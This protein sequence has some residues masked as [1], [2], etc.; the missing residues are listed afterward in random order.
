MPAS[1]EPDVPDR[2]HAGPLT[3]VGPQVRPGP[4]HGTAMAH[5]GEILQ[6]VFERDEGGLTH[7]V[8]SLPFPSLH[9]CATF[10]PGRA[11][12]V[13]VSPAWKTKAAGA[14][15]ETLRRLGVREGGRLSVHSSI[16]VERGMGSS[17]ADVVS[18]IRAVARAHGT[19]LTEEDVAALAV[20]A[21]GA[22]DGV[23]FG[24]RAVLYA[25]RDGYVLE[26][27]GGPLP[28]LEV[29]GFDVGGPDV[30]TIALPAREYHASEIEQLR[31]LRSMLRRAVTEADCALLGRTATAS[32]R[33]NQRFLPQAALPL[34]ERI[35]RD[36]DGIGVQVAHS[37]RV[38]AVLFDPASAGL[39]A[40][41][42]H[43]RRQLRAAGVRR[44]W[45]FRTEPATTGEPVLP[46]GAE[47]CEE[48]L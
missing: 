27:L 36:S 18:A 25:N 11:A 14:A 37:G 3:V 41:V 33:L 39:A 45:S 4:A 5:H 29:L 15:R 46:R 32:A 2:G 9:A 21:E 30:D 10:V 7:A 8:V 31:D 24:H 23:M 38:L 19:T 6:G 40:R 20:R 1:V 13:T 12:G 34:G 17:T 42:A 26:D 16:P 48:R 44:A 47:N 43:A 35:C 22:S 28:S